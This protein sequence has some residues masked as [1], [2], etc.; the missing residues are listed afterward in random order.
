MNM[1]FFAIGLRRW[2]GGDLERVGTA[3][4]QEEG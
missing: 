1:L 3:K 2:R 4:E